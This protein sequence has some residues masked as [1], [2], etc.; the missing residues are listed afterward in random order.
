MCNI[1]CV[2]WYTVHSYL[3]KHWGVLVSLGR[4]RISPRD[5][6]FK[7]SKN[8]FLI[9]KRLEQI[10]VSKLRL[11]LK[12]R[13]I[14]KKIN[15][16]DL[17][18]GWSTITIWHYI[19]LPSWY[20]KIGANPRCYNLKKPDSPTELNLKPEKKLPDMKPKVTWMIWPQLQQT[21]NKQNLT[22]FSCLS[23]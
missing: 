4:C 5:L 7:E 22:I 1:L 13:Q 9:K 17:E 2:M 23:L 6:H 15:L 19:I 20:E 11:V 3:H 18:H 10:H 8:K 14:K 12:L 16:R 21:Q